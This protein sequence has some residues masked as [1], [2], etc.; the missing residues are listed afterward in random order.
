[1]GLVG[2]ALVPGLVGAFAAGRLLNN[3]LY[4]SAATDVPTAAAAVAFLTTAALIARGDRLGGRP[5]W[6]PSWRCERSESAT[7]SE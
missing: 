4:E 6:T 1:M 7:P 2:F 5:G 3:M